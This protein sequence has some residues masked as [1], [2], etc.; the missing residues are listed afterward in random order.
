LA[1][2]EPQKD[3]WDW[4][5]WQKDHHELGELT[6]AIS[7]ASAAALAI[8]RLT[9]TTT[10][11]TA[12]KEGGIYDDDQIAATDPLWGQNRDNPTVAGC[13][14]PCLKSKR[15]DQLDTVLCLR[16]VQPNLQLTLDST[17]LTLALKYI[18]LVKLPWNL[19]LML[20]GVF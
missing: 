18:S 13:Q 11:C 14:G 9:A 8:S 10:K 20:I 1:A 4:T 12:A 7:A 3:P 19:T 2:Q 16:S 6:T 15:T 5:L 17:L